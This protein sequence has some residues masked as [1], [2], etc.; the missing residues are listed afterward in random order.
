MVL[1]FAPG[2]DGLQLSSDNSVENLELQ[3]DL[4]RRVVF[5][6]TSVDGLGC[7]QLRKL[8]A[9]GVVQL[10]ARE[11]VRSGHVMAEDVDVAAADA[12]G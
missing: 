5:N 9:T 3:T 6:D 12:R 1:R 4:D 8:R 7:L 11:R 2:G 10:L